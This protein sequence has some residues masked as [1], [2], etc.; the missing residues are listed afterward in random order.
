MAALRRAISLNAAAMAM[1]HGRISMARTRL[2]SVPATR[3]RNCISTSARQQQTFQTQNDSITIQS[4]SKPSPASAAPVNRQTITEKII[5]RHAIG[6]REDR[7]VKAGDYVTLRPHRSMTHDNSWPVIT[8]FMEMGASKVNDNK[9]VVMT[10]DHDVSN[11]S[12]QN[13]KK[14]ARIEEFAKKHG[15]DFYP[16]KHGIGHQIMVEEGYAWP[17]T[18][19]VASDSH[20]PI[21]GG[22]GCLGTAIVRSD[23]ASVLATSQVFWQIPPI[24]KITLTG[25]LPPGV[26]GK[27][28]ILALCA[29]L[30][31]EVLNHCVEFHGSE[32]TLASIP[33]SDR[34]TISN[35]TTEWGALSGLFPVD[36]MLISWY[37]AR[38]TVAAMSNSP[39]K[40]RINHK[41]IDELLENPLTAD[42]GATYAKEFYLNLSTLSPFVAG[43][44]SVKIA[45]PVKKLESQNISIDKAY[46]L[47]CT[48]GRHEDF[49]AA[50]RVFREAGS[51]GKPAKV[52]PNVKFYLAPASIAEQQMAKEAGDWQVLEQSGAVLL[53]AGC[54]ACIGLGPGLLEEGEV[55]ISASNRNYK[56]RMGSPKAL[57]YLASPEVV[58][59]SAIQGKI[60]S[61]GWYVKPEGVEKPIIGEG[62]GDWAADRARSA[63]DAL[64]LLIGDMESMIRTAEG[65]AEDSASPAATEAG[66]LTDILPGFPEKIEGEIV[67]CDN[68][69]INTDGIYPGRYT[70][71]DDMT[72]EQMAKVCM[73]N[74]DTEF[75]KII[76]PHDV[77]VAGSSFGSGSSREQAATSILANQIPLV[78]ASSFSSIFGRNSIN[79]ALLTLE[80]P[81]LVER[82]REAFKDDAEKP[83]TR[84]TGW[85]LLWDV[86]RS[87][88]TITQKDGISW[89]QKVGEMPPSVQE[90]VAKGGVVKWVQSKIQ[91]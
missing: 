7:K 43:P 51:D 81:K 3:F 70:Y 72:P 52:H 35:M 91:A 31:S 87:K 60:A 55:G 61:P 77:L 47:S 37:R 41:R 44:N 13:L 22:I 27:D 16:A 69:N 82:L 86:R 67:F 40:E 29:M 71:Q 32:Q 9:Q 28:T 75:G 11:H 88:V 83:L 19:A 64:D 56:G 66:T 1:R 65:A 74:Y 58:A 84:R 90:I 73:E 17:G 63:A 12:E 36:D 14:Y 48:N 38:A 5:Q 24:A 26:T 85:K 42:P 23:A 21:Y 6:L 34:L 49:A 80:L 50:A 30:Q 25:I 4:A 76:K 18:V 53:P 54:G 79:N 68:D 2:V 33:I 78:V 45:N 46:L 57:C 20:S 10:L 59:A 8:K 62:T 89:E 15:I 39:T